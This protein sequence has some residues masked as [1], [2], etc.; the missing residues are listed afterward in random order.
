[1]KKL[2]LSL[3]LL[4]S[5]AIAFGQALSKEELKAQKK[6]IKALMSEAKSAERL[7]IND[8]D[9]ALGKVTP[10][11]QNALVNGDAYVWYVQAQARK[12]IVDR[13]NATRAAGGQVDMDKLYSNCLQL[14]NELETCNKL[15]SAPDKKGKVAPKY[16]EFIKTA[17][18]EN[19]N[20][21]YNGGAYFYNKAKYAESYE[22]FGKFI[23]LT[24][25][26][27]LSD[28]VQ[29]AEKA[30]S[31]GAAYN[32]VL[33]AMQLK[34]YEKA[35]KYAD[36]AAQDEAK[37]SSIYR[38]K[39]NAYQAMG[40]N[41]K[42]IALLKEGVVKFPNDPFFYQTLIQYYD[43]AG[44]R[45]ELNALADELMANSPNNPLF[46][47]LKGYI[48]QQQDDFDTAI[49]WYKKTLEMDA[50]NVDAHINIGRSYIGKARDYSTK[51]S[52]TKIDRVQMKKDK[53]IL[54]GL[55]REALPHFERLREIIPDRT[56]KWLNDLTQCYYNLNMHDKMEELEKLAQ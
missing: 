15:D 27:I 22:Q 42:W 50:D 37:A 53:E 6:Q 51:Q 3:T 25:S 44:K 12:A 11:T 54:N 55:F 46:V 40:D 47:Y 14:I 17:L 16:T 45:D 33:C 48:A 28:V 4:L 2:I 39:A 52:S 29:P 26:D 13:D 36:Y 34:D 30:Y 21:M 32:A 18:N 5:T 7:I 41:D 43:G 49:T 56:D 38:H 1:M 23:E 9:A 10:C 35:L 24:E 8:P 19:R 31:I 20:Q